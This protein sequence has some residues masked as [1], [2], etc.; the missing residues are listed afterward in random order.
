[1][2]EILG[3]V[4]SVTQL[5]E[6]SGSLLAGG[7]GFLSKVIR[8]PSEMR[9]LLTEAAAIDSLLGQLQVIAET[10][11]KTAPNDAL[12]ALNRLGVFEECMASLKSVQKALKS[13]EQSHEKD[14]RNLGKRFLWPFKEKETKEDL[15]K[16]HRLRGLLANA[17]EASSASALRRIE[18]GQGVLQNDLASLSLDFHSHIS[19][20]EAQKVVTYFCS[21]TS[22]GA[23]SSLESALSRRAPGTGRWFLGSK[24]FKR[25]YQSKDGTIWITGLPGS[26]KTIL[27][28]SVIEQIRSKSYPTTAVLFYFCDHR[29]HSKVTHSGFLMT[30]TK[31]LL[32][33]SPECLAHAKEVYEENS[34][35]P[36]HRTE[37]VPLIEELMSRFEEILILVDALDE[38]TE[39]DQIAESLTALHGFGKSKG[40]VTKVILTSRFDLQ[41]ERRYPVITSTRITLAENMREDIDNYI[42]KELEVRMSQGSLK[43]RNKDLL[44]SVLQQVGMR[45][46]THSYSSIIYRPRRTIETS[47]ECFNPCRMD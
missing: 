12:Q 25:W 34:N 46:G 20:E 39:K 5:I 44:S 24:E 9:S 11:P 43:L 33:Q 31:Q 45:A 27:S 32:D 47:K 8:A 1:M 15:E 18:A 41:V 26:G 6:L 29:D 10:T 17:V 40:I 21:T 42:K 38:A 2:A 28:S 4:A 13:C 35:Y 22:D 19:R 16:L 30:I 7:Y 14:A 36:F 37:Y 3:I 23:Y